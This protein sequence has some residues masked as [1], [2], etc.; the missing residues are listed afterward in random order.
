MEYMSWRQGGL[1]CFLLFLA[2][3][4]RFRVFVGVG[5]GGLGSFAGGGVGGR[6]QFGLDFCLPTI[7]K[8]NKFTI[9]FGLF[10][11]R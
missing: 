9:V 8:S 6:G 4:F 11:L 10:G 5:C 1:F 7:S 2:A 3:E